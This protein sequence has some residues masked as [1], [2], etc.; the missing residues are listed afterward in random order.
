M[1]YWGNVSLV[2]DAAVLAP[3]SGEVMYPQVVELCAMNADV[4]QPFFVVVVRNNYFVL[5]MA[6]G[7]RLQCYADSVAAAAS[8]IHC[9]AAPFAVSVVKL[10][11]FVV[12]PLVVGPAM[13]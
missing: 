3:N 5:S 8:L 10:M 9:L 4:I 13:L 11:H 7:M 6:V 12:A 1:N 2:L